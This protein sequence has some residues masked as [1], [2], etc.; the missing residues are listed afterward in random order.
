MG[1]IYRMQNKVI[2][3]DCGFG[4]WCY[5]EL[6][7]EYEDIDVKYIRELYYPFWKLNELGYTYQV[8]TLSDIDFDIDVYSGDEYIGSIGGS[9]VRA[10]V[11]VVI[12]GE[13][14]IDSIIG[15]E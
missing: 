3:I 14:L 5:S 15:G 13:K 1:R 2:L 11:C 12:E 7:G 8:K 4:E 9:W 10:K 6:E